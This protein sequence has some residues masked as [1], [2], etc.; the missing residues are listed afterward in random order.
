MSNENFPIL[1]T[2][3]LDYTDGTYAVFVSRAENGQGMTVNHRVSGQNLVATLL[4]QLKAVFTVE[5]S[6][7]YATYRR[8]HSAQAS[9]EVEHTQQVSWTPEE[10][11]P[12][13]YVRPL[14][15]SASPKPM[16]IVLNGR[17][18]VHAAW[19]GQEVEVYAGAILATDQFWRAASTWQSLIRLVSD[20]TLT[21]GAYRVEAITAEGY[22]FK[23]HMHPAL[24]AS[25]VSPGGA[26]NHRDSILTAC[27][28]RG[29]ELIREEFHRDENQT[30]NQYPT[31]RALYE[32][33]RK[34]G[35]ETW[36]NGNFRADE[37]ASRLKPIE[38]GTDGNY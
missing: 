14:V 24:F 19:Q 10:I 34:S 7:P 27:L 29:L 33:L 32:K 23:V 3:R 18:G 1:S 36:D 5:V 30:W 9:G 2:D 15:L 11:V 13:V 37:V 20:D 4:K 35:I 16:N 6:S 12:P 25:M 22:Y 21:K 17:H 38:F 8:L 26:L 28:A 31:L